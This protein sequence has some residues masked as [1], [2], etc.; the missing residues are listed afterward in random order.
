M[1]IA[2]RLNKISPKMCRLIARKS[3]GQK[4]MS[5]TDIAL[6]SGLSRSTVVA[7]SKLNK[8]DNLPLKRIQAFSEA[9]GVDLLRPKTSM[10]IVRKRRL[11]FMS[12]ANSA[13][14]KMFGR[15]LGTLAATAQAGSE[16]VQS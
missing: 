11:G 5:H 7:I 2:D 1:G 12:A 4:P 9:C 16:K 8:W 3:R 13:Q 15:I 14:R 6:R 10:R